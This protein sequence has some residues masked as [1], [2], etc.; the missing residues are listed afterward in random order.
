MRGHSWLLTESESVPIRYQDKAYLLDR[1][2]QPPRSN[3]LACIT[4][5][6]QRHFL[7]QA[8]VNTVSLDGEPIYYTPAALRFRLDTTLF[9]SACVGA[10]NLDQEPGPSLWGPAFELFGERAEKILIHWAKVWAQPL[11]R[12]AIYFTPKKE[13]AL[14]ELDARTASVA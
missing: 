5:G 7:Y 14:R 1:L 3:W 9:L 6:G 8:V 11:S 4:T 10:V 13:D 12:L 2:L